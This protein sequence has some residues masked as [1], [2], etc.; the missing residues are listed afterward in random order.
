MKGGL[1]R[2]D[3]QYKQAVSSAAATEYLLPET[4]GFMEAEDE[5]EKTF[6]VRQSEIKSGVDVTTAN[7]ASFRPSIEGIWPL[8]G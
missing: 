8:W 2:I 5:M 1:R 4:T 6:K 7:K 3:D